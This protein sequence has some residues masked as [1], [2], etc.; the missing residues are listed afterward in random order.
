M[1]TENAFASAKSP[2][3]LPAI[4]PT[5]GENT[6]GNSKP[7]IGLDDAAGLSPPPCGGPEDGLRPAAQPRSD[8]EGSFFMCNEQFGENVLPTSNAGDLTP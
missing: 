2:S 3:G 4:S 6:R 5:R 8:W 1:A 7:Q